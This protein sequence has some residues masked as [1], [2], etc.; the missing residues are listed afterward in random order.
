ML[1]FGVIIF[2]FARSMY[3]K[4]LGIG[5]YNIRIMDKKLIQIVKNSLQVIKTIKL[6]LKDL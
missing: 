4:L 6:K 2:E 1:L 5:I 3:I